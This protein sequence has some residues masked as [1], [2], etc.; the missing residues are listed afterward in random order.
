MSIIV[1]LEGGRGLVLWTVN[2]CGFGGRTLW[3]GALEDFE[4]DEDP[5]S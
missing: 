1:V 5:V 3:V 4:V 2:S